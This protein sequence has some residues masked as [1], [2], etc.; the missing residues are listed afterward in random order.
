MLPWSDYR[1]QSL[2][3]KGLC[4]LEQIPFRDGMA[5]EVRHLRGPVVA[6]EKAGL[7]A[8]AEFRLRTSELR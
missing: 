6:V 8:A 3:R 4:R 2:G 7:S 5:M 1:L